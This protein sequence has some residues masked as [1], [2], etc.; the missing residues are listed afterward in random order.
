MKPS[1]SESVIERMRKLDLIDDVG[2]KLNTT[3]SAA[4]FS[5]AQPQNYTP[6]IDPSSV[7]NSKGR[8]KAIGG[9]EDVIFLNPR[10]AP[11]TP[12]AAKRDRSSTGS[13][14][15]RRTSVRSL[16][17]PRTRRNSNSSIEPLSERAPTSYIPQPSFRT[18]VGN[19]RHIASDQQGSVKRKPIPSSALPRPLRSVTDAGS[20]CMTSNQPPLKVIQLKRARGQV[21]NVMQKKKDIEPD[22]KES[23]LDAALGKGIKLSGASP[24]KEPACDVY[25]AWGLSS[26]PPCSLPCPRSSSLPV[27]AKKEPQPA[28][29]ATTI[30]S[31]WMHPN[32]CEAEDN[33]QRQ[34]N[35]SE[36]TVK[37]EPA[38]SPS[39]SIALT[40]T[41]K[42]SFKENVPPK[43]PTLDEDL[44]PVRNFKFPAVVPVEEGDDSRSDATHVTSVSS[45]SK[46]GTIYAQDESGGY[47][48]KPVSKADPKRGPRVR[49]EDSAD[50]LL[51]SEEQLAEVEAKR[52]AYKRKF[53]SSMIG[54]HQNAVVP[55][56]VSLQYAGVSHA[57]PEIQ[58]P[59]RNNSA[60]E[61]IKRSSKMLTTRLAP[62][63][64]SNIGTL[65]HSPTGWPLLI[66][67]VA[68]FA[69]VEAGRDSP[70]R[71]SA[72]E[73]NLRGD[74]GTPVR[75]GPGPA[76]ESSPA[77]AYTLR[78]ALHDIPHSQDAVS[79][80]GSLRDKVTKGRK[81]LPNIANTLGRGPLFP[82][83]T[84]S[85]TN[86]ASPPNELRKQTSA[87]LGSYVDQRANF[88]PKATNGYPDDEARHNV[89]NGTVT[90]FQLRHMQTY[91]TSLRH[92]NAH[93]DVQFEKDLPSS[94][95]A[96]PGTVETG[97]AKMMSTMRGLMHKI[98]KDGTLSRAD[99]KASVM[100]HSGGRRGS[101]AGNYRSSPLALASPTSP[102]ST[103]M[104]PASAHGIEK[105]SNAKAKRTLGLSR[106]AHGHGTRTTTITT[107]S[108]N[109]PRDTSPVP[110]FQTS[111][112][113]PLE[114]RDA[115]ALAFSLLDRARDRSDNGLDAQR[116]TEYVELAKVVVSTVTLAREA[117][118]AMEE[119]KMA[120]ARAEMECVRMRRAIGEV[121]EVVR[122]MVGMGHRGGSGEGGI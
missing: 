99:S 59:K 100:Y 11:G 41:R 36:I 112:L 48:L 46:A 92:H 105:T 104:S 106:L 110:P 108:S 101:D 122:R 81:S 45:A 39:S 62:P 84:L 78:T 8:G 97:K 52:E 82:P 89:T 58:S 79:R 61:E 10:P 50:H 115:T 57:H 77:S 18:S 88:S 114:I 23:K 34:S 80:G 43:S 68:P 94:P 20:P 96:M 31:T 73:S 1:L 74:A 17:I 25:A 65:S 21:S 55:E 90:P 56:L 7:S 91:N 60:D 70:K 120:A 107:T 87:L 116:Q 47:R 32:A 26:Q 111:A 118:K 71:K 16:K 66:S 44:S 5:K 85:K 93:Q 102:A 75:D 113:E 24:T 54:G 72:S 13:V 3:H 76:Y 51:L 4:S 121:N 9:V 117:E 49:I 15:G 35:S 53:S 30:I 109:R 38:S 2:R 67:K 6:K 29:S 69:E 40:P 27:I 63:V 98:S 83:R 95:T 64:P 42:T 119:A 103:K 22:E 19:D 37:K 14:G 12:P 33:Q 28:V 86:Q